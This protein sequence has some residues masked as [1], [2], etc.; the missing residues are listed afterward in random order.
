MQKQDVAMKMNG[1]GQGSEPKY[2]QHGYGGKGSEPK[3]K[4]INSGVGSASRY[5]QTAHPKSAS[6]KYV[7]ANSDGAFSGK[8]KEANAKVT[9]PMINGNVKP[10]QK[11]KMSLNSTGRNMAEKMYLGKDEHNRA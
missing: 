6:S 10:N 4:Q 3:F 1:S 7:Q 9:K 2:T 5:T 8:Y 11:G